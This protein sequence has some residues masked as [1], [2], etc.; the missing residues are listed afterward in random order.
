MAAYIFFI[1]L[2]SFG[3]VSSVL[4][5]PLP[6]TG[7]VNSSTTGFETTSSET[8]TVGEYSYKVSFS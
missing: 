1:L 4:W 2:Y 3:T 8:K 7:I 6:A 5:N